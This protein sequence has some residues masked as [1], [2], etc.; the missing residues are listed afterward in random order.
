MRLV[1]MWP[2]VCNDCAEAVTQVVVP[3]T[4]FNSPTRTT[5][6]LDT[7]ETANNAVIRRALRIMESRLKYREVALSSPQAVRDY[8]RL[9]LA[10]REHEVFVVLFLDLCAVFPYV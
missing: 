8:L 1:P 5:R 4:D 3:G 2:N 10:D 9:R 7:A 6:A